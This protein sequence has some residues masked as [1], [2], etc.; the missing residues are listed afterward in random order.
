MRVLTFIIC[1]FTLAPAAYGFRSAL[2]LRSRYSHLS[3]TKNF[4][5]DGKERNWFQQMVQAFIEAFPEVLRP[6]KEMDPS[7][8][9]YDPAS[10]DT[11]IRN[12][13]YL[14]ILIFHEIISLQHSIEQPATYSGDARK[15]HKQ[16]VDAAD[17][18]LEKYQSTSVEA[19]A[20]TL[21]S[22]NQVKAP[23]K[24]DVVN[25]ATA[26]SNRDQT[27]PYISPMMMKKTDKPSEPLFSSRKIEVRPQPG[28]SKTIYWPLKGNTPRK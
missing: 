22:D 10:F 3:A 17:H 1:A 27:V 23:P 21:N 14:S 2:A 12:F 16:K 18:F 7:K 26:A 6:P 13:F 15:M 5:G 25:T 20:K 8:V 9:I 19:P 4:P 28:K 11:V 24:P